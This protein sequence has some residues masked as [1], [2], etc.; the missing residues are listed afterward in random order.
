MEIKT[1]ANLKSSQEKCE[2]LS[3]DLDE[4]NAKLHKQL[5]RYGNNVYNF[6]FVCYKTLYLFIVE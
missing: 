3:Q 6:E 1:E 2:E 5:L 4:R